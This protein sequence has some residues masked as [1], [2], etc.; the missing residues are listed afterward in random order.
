MGQRDERLA[1]THTLTAQRAP[2]QLLKRLTANEETLAS[3]SKL[4]TAAVTAKRRITPAGE[5]L[6]DNFY[7]IQEQIRTARRHFPKGYSRELPRLAHGPSA[8]PSIARGN[9]RAR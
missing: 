2:Y 1:A 3:V 8:N 6:L 4:L 5:W 7:L 9:Y